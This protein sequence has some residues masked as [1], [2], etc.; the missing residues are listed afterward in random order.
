MPGCPPW[1]SCYLPQRIMECGRKYSMGKRYDTVA[2]G[3]RIGTRK[4]YVEICKFDALNLGNL[5][6]TTKV[7]QLHLM[8]MKKDSTL[9]L[10]SDKGGIYY[11]TV[12]N[13][14]FQK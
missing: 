8:N 11:V 10:H 7:F 12:L 14:W 5:S 9:V 4:K 2:T 1:F 13:G 3:K 6:E